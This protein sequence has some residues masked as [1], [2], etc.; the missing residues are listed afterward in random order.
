MTTDKPWMTPDA[1]ALLDAILRDRA[2]DRLPI[3]A[4]ALEEGGFAEVDTPALLA[5]RDNVPCDIFYDLRILRRVVEGH[6]SLQ[7]AL[8]AAAKMEELSQRFVDDNKERFQDRH[9]YDG[10]YGTP[11][12]GMG[13]LAWIMGVCD[14]WMKDEEW[15]T[16]GYNTPA[17]ADEV[18]VEMWPLYEI[19]TGT[20]APELERYGD[21]FYTVVPFSCSC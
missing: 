6:V 13:T 8:A 16:F 5:M 1:K 9:E 17:C 14:N 3:L 11:P 18:A 10:G 21:R 12:E 15:E 19:L 2:Y 7:T 4:D 20:P